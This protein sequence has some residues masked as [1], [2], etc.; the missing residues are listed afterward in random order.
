MAVQPAQTTRALRRATRAIRENLHLTRCRP[1]LGHQQVAGAVPYPQWR[2]RSPASRWPPARADL[3]PVVVDAW[4]APRDAQAGLPGAL[5]V[6]PA[7][8]GVPALQDAPRALQADAQLL[9]Q[10]PRQQVV[11]AQAAPK[12]A[13]TKARAPTVPRRYSSA[14]S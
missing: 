6:A 7:L 5:R 12:R 4:A 9:Q 10:R 14:A 2:A 1:R 11:L 3:A 13:L 8:R